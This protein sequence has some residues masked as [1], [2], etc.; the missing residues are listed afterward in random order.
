MPICV[1]GTVLLVSL[2]V[3]L[4]SWSNSCSSIFMEGILMQKQ[5]KKQ[6]WIVAS[7]SCVLK[8]WLENCMYTS[9]LVMAVYFLLSLNPSFDSPQILTF[10]GRRH[11]QRQALLYPPRP[12]CSLY[13]LYKPFGYI[14]T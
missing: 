10:G 9:L 2:I 1:Y 4:K 13:G 14:S 12:P 7:Y 11:L 5:Y 3:T 8:M 6:I